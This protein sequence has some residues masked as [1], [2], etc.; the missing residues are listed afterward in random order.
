VNPCGILKTLVLPDWIPYILSFEILGA[1][2]W[3]PEAWM[4][5]A[6]RIGW[7]WKGWLLDGRR[8]LEENSHTLELEEPGGYIYIYIYVCIDHISI[9]SCFDLYGMMLYE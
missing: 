7:D 5:G 8:G 6:G 2:I 9:H 1:W 4:R 3:M